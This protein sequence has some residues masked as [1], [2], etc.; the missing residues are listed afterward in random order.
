[1]AVDYRFDWSVLLNHSDALLKGA[2]LTLQLTSTT[3]VFG[4]FL[5]VVCAALRGSGP[6]WARTIVGIYVEVVRN[7]PFLIQLL[8]IFIGLPSAGIRLNANAAATLAMTLNFGA[9]GC[10]IVRSGIDAVPY[11]QIEA[12]RALGLGRLN[13]F[14]HIV[15]PQAIR[16]CY[17]AL[18]SQ[19]T[20]VM[21]GS[22]VASA[23]GADELSATANIV[24]SQTFRSFEIYLAVTGMYLV[25]AL[26]M[27]LILRVIHKMF[28]ERSNAIA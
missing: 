26:M 13:I 4:F 27:R 23:I 9:Y 1:M 28:F 8:I 11:G 25:L 16:A 20:I 22:S 14:R 2:L 5:A 7:T 17:P 3:I 18:A 6:A 15:F 24:Q 21:L 12:G 10:E 19:F